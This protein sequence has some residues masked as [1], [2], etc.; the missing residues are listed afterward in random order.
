MI[1]RA[2]QTQDLTRNLVVVVVSISIENHLLKPNQR[3]SNSEIKKS[4]KTNSLF[5]IWFFKSFPPPI[6][7]L[8]SK[9]NLEYPSS[10]GFWIHS[11]HHLIFNL[12]FHS[13]FMTWFLEMDKKDKSKSNLNNRREHPLPPLPPDFMYYDH[14]HINCL[15]LYFT[16]TSADH[17][18][19]STF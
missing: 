14:R 8:L 12:S 15:N 18:I 10:C 5:S 13:S 1:R 4:S 6:F 2:A 9:T 19:F 17:P 7:L 3:D 16:S 11:S